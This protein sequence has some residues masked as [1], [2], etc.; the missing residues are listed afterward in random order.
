MSRSILRTLAAVALVAAT[1]AVA[2]A[3][4]SCTIQ[5]GSAS[6]QTCNFTGSVSVPT[7]ARLNVTG[8][9]LTGSAL[10]LTSPDWTTY[11]SNPT[12]TQTLS[13]VALQV[14]ANTS[15]AVQINS[16]AAWTVPAGGSRALSTLTYTS[17]AGACPAVNT[18]T[19]AI[20]A[21]PAALFNGAS[22]TAS[23]SRNLCF[24][25]SWGGALDGG[26]LA[27]GSYSLPIT[28]TLSAP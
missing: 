16:A 3:Q 12:A 25:L 23:T 11:L 6:P 13:Q 10:T 2:E 28:L 4:V 21:S 9:S 14:R 24:A 19:T 1:A 26:D 22:A 18:I 15:Y 5:P 8:D 17:V 7:L 20:T 27:P